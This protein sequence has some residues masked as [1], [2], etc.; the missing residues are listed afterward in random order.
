MTGNQFSASHQRNHETGDDLIK[1]G[2]FIKGSE[3]LCRCRCV[4]L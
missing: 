4:T 3:L 1:I 2:I